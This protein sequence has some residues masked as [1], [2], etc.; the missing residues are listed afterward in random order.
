MLKNMP[1]YTV[2]RD[3]DAFT[4]VTVG[5]TLG[6][7]TGFNDQPR[8]GPNVLFVIV[9]GSAPPRAMLEARGLI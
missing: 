9:L 3:L 2:D 1:R 8:I 7:W 6:V 4:L 5:Y